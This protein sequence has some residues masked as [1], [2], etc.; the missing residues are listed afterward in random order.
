M[1]GPVGEAGAL[2]DDPAEPFRAEVREWLRTAPRPEALHDYGPTPTVA[3]IPAGREWQ[4]TLAACGF[5]C[6]HWPVR[7]GGRDATVTE[8]AVF[9]EEAARASVPRQLNIVGPDL[10]GPVLMAF[11]TEAQCD[12][13]L[14][15][16]RTGDDM[17]C[18]LFSEPDAGSDLAAVR[19]RARRVD[20]GWVVDGQ[21]VWTSGG[22]GAEYGLLLARSG[23]PGH[24]GLSVFV[25]AM[26]SPGVTVRPLLQMDGESKFNEV[27]LSGVELPPDAL[28]GEEGQGWRVATA[29]LGRERLSLGANAVGMFHAL[30]DLVEAAAARGRLDDH[31]RGQVVD[32]WIRTWLLRATWERAIAEGAEPGAP[33]FSVLKLLT[34][35]THRAIGDLGVEALGPDA[36]WSEDGEPL[37]HRMLVGHAQ[38]ILG[39]TSEIQRNILAERVL[40]LPREPTRSS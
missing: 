36:L 14:P 7:W 20:G 40:G 28:V 32:L 4:H 38:T 9:A 18:Q 5:A 21:K 15:R 37:V 3:D 24:G 34:S 17:W 35:E 6:L 25:V 12:R 16:I 39:G 22:D 26:N 33:S 13:Y 29:T 31:L 27:F 30:D 2:P 8:Q 10:A 1:D 23:G 19:T 11:G